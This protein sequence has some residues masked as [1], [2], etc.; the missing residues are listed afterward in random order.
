MSKRKLT[1]YCLLLAVLIFVACVS[2]TAGESQAHYINT[3]TWDTFLSPT[4]PASFESDCLVEGGQTILLG[5][6]P[7]QSHT[8]IPFTLPV[9]TGKLSWTVSE[10]ALA[11][12]TL[13]RGETEL[14]SGDE[15]TAAPEDRTVVLRVAPTEAA[16]NSFHNGGGL[17]IAVTWTGETTLSGTFRL[18]LPPRRFTEEGQTIDLK[19]ISL[20]GQDVTIPLEAG[21]GTLSWA[22]LEEEPLL[23]AAVYQGDTE[24]TNG[25]EVTIAEEAGALTLK[26]TPTEEAKDSFHEAQELTVELIWTTESRILKGTVKVTVPAVTLNGQQIQLGELTQE[27]QV[28]T[29]TL[30]EGTGTLSWTLDQGDQGE[31]DTPATYIT[32]SVQNG[33]TVVDSGT[34]MTLEQVST[35]TLTILP[36]EDAYF[37]THDEITCSVTVEWTCQEQTQTAVFFVMIPFQEVLSGSGGQMEEEEIEFSLRNTDDETGNTGDIETY[38]ETEDPQAEDLPTEDPTDE[39]TTEP[40][41]ASEPTETQPTGEPAVSVTTLTEFDPAC[42]LPARLN[43][44]AETTLVRLTLADADGNA[45]DLPAFTRYS[46]DG[47]SSWYMLYYGG[48]LEGVCENLETALVLLDFSGAALQEQLTF[49]LEAF[50]AET[51]LGT[52]LLEART[53]TEAI[54]VTEPILTAASP[55]K[56]TFPTGWRGV[57]TEYQ[58]TRLVETEKTVTAEDGTQSEQTVREYVD[59]PFDTKVLTATYDRGSDE[60]PTN[61][62]TLITGK[63][64]APDTLWKVLP[65]GTYRITIT[66][67]YE[68]ISFRT[69]QLTFFVQHSLDLGIGGE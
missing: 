33:E 44:P 68:N 38:S 61:T 37:S 4:E 15:L 39:T 22:I 14:Q 58:V 17:E 60:T 63:P 46:L 52:A 13:L 6:L 2:V 47:G 42:L 20:E 64:V 11:T 36:T 24:L 49:R 7:L 35:L 56:L 67:T 34:T 30:P 28:T 18:T 59:V 66:W 48:S 19:Q 45:A 26:L 50:T 25:A 43:F 5:E 10:T 57:E 55:L 8:D 53:V 21:T 69:Q 29:F 41:D 40:T 23:T 62:L 9:E 3:D 1:A 65:A 31:T 54:T 12:V 51:S 27:G 16:M 32:A